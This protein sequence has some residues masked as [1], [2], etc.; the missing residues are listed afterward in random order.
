M[1]LLPV[2]HMT[3]P[4]CMSAPPLPTHTHGSHGLGSLVFG[5]GKSLKLPT[6]DETTW[7]LATRNLKVTPMLFKYLVTTPAEITVESRV[8]EEGRAPRLPELQADW[9]WPKTKSI[10]AC[11]GDTEAPPRPLMMAR[12][13]STTTTLSSARTSPS[14][15]AGGGRTGGHLDLPPPPSC[16]VAAPCRACSSSPSSSSRD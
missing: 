8:V 7:G 1:P 3:C 11:R 14:L 4:C 16:P 9:L 5:R 15:A 13:P 2:P 10:G 12:S 6:S